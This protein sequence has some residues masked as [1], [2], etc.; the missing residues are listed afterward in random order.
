MIV[1]LKG[2]DRVAILVGLKMYQRS[3]MEGNIDG[4]PE[5]SVADV[6]HVT[7]LIELFESQPF[8]DD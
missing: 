6:E 8:D 4:D 5:G 2:E 7:K 1:K 3:I